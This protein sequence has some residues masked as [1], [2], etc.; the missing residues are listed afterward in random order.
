[1]DLVGV[2]LAWHYKAAAV[3]QSYF[4]ILSMFLELGSHFPLSGASYQATYALLGEIWA[5]LIGWSNILS[6]AIGAS[7]AAA[8]ASR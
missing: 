5:F 1:M 7:A 8:A 2:K 6:H 3:N 4:K